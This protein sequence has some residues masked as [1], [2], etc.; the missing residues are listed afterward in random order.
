MLQYMYLPLENVRGTFC[1]FETSSD[2]QTLLLKGVKR[3][4][5][6]KQASDKRFQ[7]IFKI[8]NLTRS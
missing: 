3:G 5:T 1:C 6:S 2:M 7:A 8:K 4:I